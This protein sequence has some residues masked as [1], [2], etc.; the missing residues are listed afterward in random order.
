M[1]WTQAL[2]FTLDV[3]TGHWQQQVYLWWKGLAA[4]ESAILLRWREIY[5][6]FRCFY[7]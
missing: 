6:E 4:S 5:H 2:L 3:V 1:V 7:H